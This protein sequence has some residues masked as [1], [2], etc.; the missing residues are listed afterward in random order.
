MALVEYAAN[1]LFLGA[2][3]A[4]L[5]V[6]MSLVWATTDVIDIATGG[7]AVAAG[8]VAV[9]VGM[10][11][12]V[13]AGIAAA[14]LLGALSGGIFLGFHALRTMRDVMLIVLA[15]FALML[16]IESAVLT[17]VGTTT[18]FLDPM[19]G[20]LEIGDLL[21]PYQGLLN[22]AIA[23]LLMVLLSLVLKFTPIG[24]RMRACAVSDRSARLAGIPV[25]QT[26][27]WTFVVAA[28]LAGTAGVLAAFSIGM[29]YSSTFVFT[30]AA[31]SSVVLFGRPGPLPAFAGAIL[32]GLVQSIGEGYLPN[33]WA[34]GLPSLLIIFVLASGVV[35][36]AVFKGA[37]P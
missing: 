37:R 25:R 5:A 1:G 33:G 3:Y 21:L 4:L 6:P 29:A 12:G 31:F 15:T 11:Y 17:G 27:F 18:L 2:I 10:P 13:V 36:T 23:V 9:T 20:N 30:I 14:L 32:L 35:P 19:R 34:G 22:L 26:Q 7:Y 16:A 24:L 8:V 28:G